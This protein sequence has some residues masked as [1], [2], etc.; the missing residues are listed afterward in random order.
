MSIIETLKSKGI[1]VIKTDDLYV[2]YTNTEAGY[3]R[4]KDDP[5]NSVN[6]L[7]LSTSQRAIPCN[8]GKCYVSSGTEYQDKIKT[9]KEAESL[10]EQGKIYS[11]KAFDLYA[12]Y[13]DFDNEK[14]LESFFFHKYSTRTRRYIEG[15]MHNT[16]L[17]RYTDASNGSGDIDGVPTEF[18]VLDS[19]DLGIDRVEIGKLET[20]EWLAQTCHQIEIDDFEVIKMYFINKPSAKTVKTAFAIRNFEVS[21]SREVFKCWECG[22]LTNWLDTPGDFAEKLNHLHDRYCG[23]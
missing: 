14:E 19:F 22:K 5:Q 16:G 2:G 17:I 12:E 6:F 13:Y 4:T 7:R 23:C 15:V 20:G 3:V 1:E 10:A 9:V 18:D 8:S 11:F 21:Q